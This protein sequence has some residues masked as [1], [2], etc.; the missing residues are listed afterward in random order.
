MNANEP[1]KVGDRVRCTRAIIQEANLVDGF[2]EMIVAHRGTEGVIVRP[3]PY[4][5]FDWVV[6]MPTN[7][8][9]APAGFTEDVHVKANEI[10]PVEAP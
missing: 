9:D 4:E 7:A 6:H 2:P 8:L 3:S 5:S 1:V 10:A